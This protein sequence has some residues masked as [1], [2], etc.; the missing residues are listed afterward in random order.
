MPL[1]QE[2]LQ[3]FTFSLLRSLAEQWGVKTG[4]DKYQLIERLVSFG[5]GE[6]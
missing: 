6:K 2:S 5:Q 3:G 1:T 4:G